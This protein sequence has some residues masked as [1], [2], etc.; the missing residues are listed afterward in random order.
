MNIDVAGVYLLYLE[1]ERRKKECLGG[2][3]SLDGFACVR[4]RGGLGHSYCTVVTVV[5]QPESVELV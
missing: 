4:G 1:P 2:I 5:V 3:S